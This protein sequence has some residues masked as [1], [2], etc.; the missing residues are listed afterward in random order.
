LTDRELPVPGSTAGYSASAHVLPF[1]LMLTGGWGLVF[2]RACEGN[3]P[4]DKKIAAVR[5]DSTGYQAAIFSLCEETGKVF[6]I[7]ADQDAAV[8]AAIAAIPGSGWRKFRH[9]EIGETVHCERRRI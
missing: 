5:A 7:G 9:C 1:V 8:K 4:K 6:A 3:I 2:L